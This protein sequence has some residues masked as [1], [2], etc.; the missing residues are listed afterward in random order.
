MDI[1]GSEAE[2]I[3]S[4]ENLN[5]VNSLFIEYHS[6]KDSEQTLGAIL[7]KISACGFRY[8][9][10]TQFCSSRPLTKE[11]LHLGMDLQLNIFCRR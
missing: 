6:F 7:N 8:Y 10:H 5:A 4:S 1:E 11:K 9:I 2:V 3:C